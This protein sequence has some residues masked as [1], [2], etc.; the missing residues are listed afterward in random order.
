MVLLFSLLAGACVV[1]FSVLATWIL[2]SRK[3]ERRTQQ[4]LRNNTAL[5]AAASHELR[6]PLHSVL[7]LIATLKK[8][9]T[10]QDPEVQ[11][12][13]EKLSATGSKLHRTL[14]DV[15]DTVELAESKIEL[16]PEAVDVSALLKD[17][18]V[19]FKKGLATQYPSLRIG[20]N[21][22]RN[23]VVQ[24]DPERLR[25][26]IRL[27]LLQA[28]HQT[29]S[30][31]ISVSL[32]HKAK[33]NG[34]SEVCLTVRD[35]SCGMDQWAADTYFIP[36]EAY[37]N[38]FLRGRPSAVLSMNLV[39]GFA[40]LM[41]GNV[42]ATSTMRGGV[43]FDFEFT[44]K[45]A[46][47]PAIQAEET[48]AARKE[49]EAREEQQHHAVEEPAEEQGSE[50]QDDLT[51]LL[52]QATVLLVDDVET[53]LMVMEAFLEFFD[54][55]KVISVQSGAAA[56]GTLKH[57]DCDLVFMDIQMP[58]MDGIETT[59]MIRQLN[60]RCAA[61][62]VI[63]V[64]ACSEEEMGGRCREVG[65]TGYVRKP[66]TEEELLDGILRAAPHIADSITSNRS[67]LRLA[68]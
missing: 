9:A 62:P 8:T 27:L 7:G 47:Q 57:T 25:Q 6:T 65:M 48:S 34:M 23:I 38:P 18:L 15:L 33:I 36:D 14:V 1:A 19:R 44:A 41:N 5:F 56:L 51:S 46:L 20:S 55:K 60:D 42:R 50:L 21:I 35:T 40:E 63:A 43:S 58:E 28:A 4:L 37:K 59:R 61:V 12:R 49:T 2:V 16:K 29:K 17:T 3:H 10:K 26:C 30:G 24:A 39:R 32:Q 52:R 13:I 11:R 31:R 66:I 45:T 22:M 54:V 64:S 68:S 53:N 67:V